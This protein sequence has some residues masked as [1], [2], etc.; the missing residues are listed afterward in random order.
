[1]LSTNVMNGA[2][3]VATA[4]A[5]ICELMGITASVDLIG[6]Q[7]QLIELPSFRDRSKPYF[8][9]P[10]VALVCVY[11]ERRMYTTIRV[12]LSSAPNAYYVT[13]G[14]RTGLQERLLVCSAYERKTLCGTTTQDDCEFIRRDSTR[15]YI[16]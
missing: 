13:F 3:I 10:C 16:W 2:I 15:P 9:F 11:N 4:G 8:R 12:F 7:E 1:M 5:E 6:T 14:L